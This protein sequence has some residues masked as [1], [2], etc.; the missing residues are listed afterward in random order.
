MIFLGN[1][2]VMVGLNR[3]TKWRN[4]ELWERKVSLLHWG[5]WHSGLAQHHARTPGPIWLSLTAPPRR[6]TITRHHRR[7]LSYLFR[8]FASASSSVQHLVVITVADLATTVAT[9][10]T[11][12]AG[13]GADNIIT[14]IDNVCVKVAVQPPYTGSDGGSLRDSPAPLPL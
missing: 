3:R 4:I 1:F 7:V 12:A 2:V 6:L 5:C 8:Q 10:T 13:T 11:A 9:V 14:G